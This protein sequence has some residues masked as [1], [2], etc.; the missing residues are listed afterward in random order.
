[1][2]HLVLTLI[3]FIL[4]ITIYAQ[5]APDWTWALGAG[6]TGLDEGFSINTDNNGN[7]YLCGYYEG[8]ADFGPYSITSLGDYD[9][10]IAKMDTDGNWVWVRS[11]GGTGIDYSYDFVTDSSGNSF[12]TGYY[13]GTANFGT[14]ALTSAGSLDICVFKLDTDGNW[15]WAIR[16]GGTGYDSGQSIALDDSGN[17]YVT[18]SYAIAA[19][20]GSYHLDGFGN[21]DIYVAKLSPAGNWLWAVRAGGSGQDHGYGI[22]ADGS[23]NCYIIGY[24]NLTAAFGMTDLQSSGSR[25]IVT[26]KLDTNGV[27]QWARRSGG[28]DTDIGYGIALDNSGNCYFT[29]TFKTTSLF[30]TTSIA[31][32]GGN[33]IFIAK[34]NSAGDWQ[35]ALG[36]GAS[37]SDY[38]YDIRVDAS[39]NSFVTGYFDETVSFGTTSLTTSGVADV[40]VTCLDS[41]GIWQWAVK[42]GGTYN[43]YGRGIACDGNG[44]IFVTGYFVTDPISF[45]THTITSSG[46]QDIFIAKLSDS[47]APG[48]PLPPQNL[49]ITKSGN[50]M[51]L[52]WDAVTEDT[53]GQP[54]TPD[55]YEIYYHPG[56]PYAFMTPLGQ[57]TS[58][59]YAHTGAALLTPGFYF[60]KA[61]KTD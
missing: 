8:T 36:A 47:T 12:V 21:T 49:T 45:G 20:F 15:Q 22:A 1:M 16:A 54:V 28:N 18:G 23:G 53:S 52:D 40:F 55:Y 57:T 26:A 44:S 41:S 56:D 27:W 7:I 19:D 10:F 50:D 2:K 4:S 39:G 43:D 42:A 13:S 5:P 59:S 30:G 37:S 9:I 29:G 17:C 60:V 14:D 58:T 3:I 31:S 38:G 11:A 32:N 6:G 46:L 24:F 48:F 25:D 51:L 61:V 35:W 33:D 34:M